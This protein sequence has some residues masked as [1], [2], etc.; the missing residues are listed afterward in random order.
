[1]SALRPAVPSAPWPVEQRR[2]RLARRRLALA[3]HT[4]E[5][6]D[7][8]AAVLAGIHEAGYRKG[9]ALR[10]DRGARYR[11]MQLA[12]EKA[13]PLEDLVAIALQGPDGAAAVIAGLGALVDRLGHALI[14]N[15]IGAGEARQLR[16]AMQGVFG[17]AFDAWLRERR[18]P[19]RR[20]DLASA[21]TR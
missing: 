20:V 14:P 13:L 12:G 5:A 8:T 17:A 10:C 2:C 7:L 1:L 21:A 11:R 6:I 3:Q 15:Q 19:R 18:R 4:P 16:A 9:A